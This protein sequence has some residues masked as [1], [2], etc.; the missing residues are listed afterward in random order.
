MSKNLLNDTNCVKPMLEYVALTRRLETVF[1]DVTPL[2][3]IIHDRDS[4]CFFPS[5]RPNLSIRPECI[6]RS[7]F[8]VCEGMKKR[9][10][11][12]DVHA[13]AQSLTTVLVTTYSLS[14]S[15]TAYH[16]NREIILATATWSNKWGEIYLTCG[17]GDRNVATSIKPIR[18][19]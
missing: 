6:C 5:L 11:A 4:P 13:S 16:V 19:E 1:G 18:V 3:D 12:D 8:M 14:I 17:H 15:H 9:L 2:K 7:W 10:H